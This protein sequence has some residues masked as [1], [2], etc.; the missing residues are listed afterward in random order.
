VKKVIFYAVVPLLFMG[1]SSWKEGSNFSVESKEAA[2]CD[3]NLKATNRGSERIAFVQRDDRNRKNEV[4]LHSEVRTRLGTWLSFYAGGVDPGE[5]L[6]V[7]QRVDFGCNARRRYRFRLTKGSGSSSD[8]KH[9][10]YYPS[11]TGFTQSTTLNL[12]DVNRFF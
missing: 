11:T 7:V 6:S 9:T 12:G 1:S 10:Y 4:L 3:I 2:V 5:T 8:P